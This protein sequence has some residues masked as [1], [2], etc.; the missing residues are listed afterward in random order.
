M[1]R[2]ILIGNPTNDS[3]RR[4]IAHLRDNLPAHYTIFHNLEVAQGA[5]IFELDLIILASHC[6]FVVDVKGTQG[7]VEVFGSKWYPTERQPFHSPLA[8][9]RQHAKVIKTLVC[10]TYPHKPELRRIHVHAAVLMTAP[11]AQV[12]DHGRLDSP[13]VT[14]L[15][16]CVTYFQDK[17]RIPSNRSDDIKMLLPTIE[18]AIRGKARPKSSAQRYRDWQVEEKLGGDDRYTEYRARNTFIGQ[19]AGTARLRVYKVDPYQ[20]TAA[21]EAQRKFISNSF[22]AVVQMPAHQNILAVREFFG[23]EEGDKLILVTEDLAGNALQQHI[24]RANLAL[25][26][27]QKLGII[28]DVLS[29]LD[30][31]HRHGVVHRNITPDS[32]LVG[33][34]GHA[35]L[36][37]FD[38]ARVGQ[39]RQSTIAGE[40]V[41]DLDTRFQ[42]PEAYRDPASATPLSDLFSAGL[43]FYE[44]LTGEPAFAGVEQMVDAGAVFAIKPSELKSD[45]PSGLDEWLQQLCA[46]GPAERFA[47]AQKALR[48]LADLFA[49]P[50]DSTASTTSND[51]PTTTPEDLTDLPRDYVLAN[52]FHVQE[53]L[54]EPGGFAV[55]Y[56]VYDNLGDII[57]VLKLVTRDRHSVYERLKREYQTLNRVPR[58]PHVVEV[59]WADRLPDETPFILFEYVEGLDV[60]RQIKDQSLSRDD[61]V[62]LA[63]E[64]ASGL[65]HLHRHGVYHQDIKPSNLLW[66]RDGVR[67]IDFN[68]AVSDNDEQGGGGGTRRYIPPDYD[69]T[70][71]ATPAEKIDRDVYALAV[72]FYECLTGSYPFEDPTPPA[73]KLARDPRGFQGCDDLSDNLVDFLYRALSPKRSD[74]YPTAQAFLSALTALSTSGDIRK[75]KPRVPAVSEQSVT[76]SLDLAPDKPNFNPFV[77]YLLTLYS[78]SQQTNAGTRGLDRVGEMTYISTLLDKSLQPAILDGEFSLIII[79]GNAGDGKTAFVQQLE[80]QAEREGASVSHT[81]NGCI[82]E[83]RGRRFV[84]NYDG[85]QDEGDKDNENVLSDFFGPFAGASDASWEVRETRVIAINEGR[86]VDFLSA[87]D[88]RFQRLIEIVRAGFNGEEP[89]G[90]VAVVNLNLRSVVA[91][92]DGQQS[93]IFD[94]LIRRFTDPRLWGACKSCDLKDQCYIYHNAQTF[95][96]ETAGPKVAERLKTIHT[97]AH[98]RGRLHITLRDL[99]SALA[100]MLAGTRNCDEVHALYRDTNPYTAQEI[101]DGHYFNSWMGGTRGSADRLI[102]LLRETDV[103]ETS[104]PELD[105]LFGLLEPDD[106]ELARFGF[107]ERSRYSDDLLSKAF[108]DLPY[109]MTGKAGPRR[110]EAYKRYVSVMRRR[111]YFERRDEGWR[112]MLPHRSATSFLSLVLESDDLSGFVPRLLEAIN[113]GEGLRARNRLVDKLALRVRQVAKGTVRSYRLFDRVRFALVRPRLAGGGRFVEYLPQQLLLRYES[114]TGHRAELGINLDVYEMLENLNDGYRP[115]IEQQ[116]GFYRNLTVFKNLLGSAPYQ[117]VL[118]TETGHE[119]FRINRDETGALSL[120]RLQRDHLHEHQGTR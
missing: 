100:F 94:R 83:L 21:Q 76:F 17:S 33:A 27:D 60:E 116:E 28:R 117:E 97:V 2:V 16:K 107:S 51:A 88:H 25:T 19:R 103:G 48:E 81:A 39:N 30:H 56:K 78:Q 47:D 114:A 79:S 111:Y 66:T 85:S 71:D 1:A 77:S 57:R 44:L 59:L 96:D 46:F 6:V 119:F 9:L 82:F 36:A 35:R 84:T 18:Q 118:L 38:Y 93:S 43:V 55:A 106:Q 89:S 92:L 63:R 24:R 14:Y 109:D 80:R 98:M 69:I 54:G 22:R 105:R 32:I 112:D 29:A 8:K 104:N 5:E 41:D 49:P 4:A 50:E 102:S 45:L 70:A 68:V 20:E 23:T 113:R 40:I 115:S 91:D 99:R 37:G 12:I 13:D 64:V 34:D 73:S 110:R 67:I 75:P 58:H 62:R 65:E 108:A 31:T 42:A 26:L 61:A 10:D 3:E 95:M 120:I 74:R 72:T 52:R 15:N 53:R 101:L 7:N 86:L 11:D 87:H 90:G